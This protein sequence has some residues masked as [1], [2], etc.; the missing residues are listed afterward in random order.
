MKT[1]TT[2]SRRLAVQPI[3]LRPSSR[4]PITGYKAMR[5]LAAK[6]VPPGSFWEFSR[7]PKIQHSKGT[8]MQFIL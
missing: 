5:R 8:F 7:N 4:K 3:P 6:D 2:G 1:R